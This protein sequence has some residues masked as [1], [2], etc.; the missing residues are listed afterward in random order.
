MSRA[1][2]GLHSPLAS[3]VTL[4]PPTWSAKTSQEKWSTMKDGC[5]LHKARRGTPSR[6]ACGRGMPKTYGTRPGTLLWGDPRSLELTNFVGL[7]EEYRS[8]GGSRTDGGPR[9]RDPRGT[10]HAH[11]EGWGATFD[12][13]VRER[14]RDGQLSDFEQA[15][16]EERRDWAPRA[17]PGARR[18]RSVLV[19][20]HERAYEPVQRASSRAL[21]TTTVGRPGG[22]T[23]D[24]PRTA[25]LCSQEVNG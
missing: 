10:L 21:P 2:P 18:P 23:D 5:S 11:G 1:A 9:R 6:R 22:A 14:L 13:H 8:A 24:E 4:P 3:P 15:L 7:G 12:D 17:N 20:T 16:R 19:R 25:A